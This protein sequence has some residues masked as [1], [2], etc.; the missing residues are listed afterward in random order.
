MKVTMS[1]FI[2]L[3][4][5]VDD[6]INDKIVVRKADNLLEDYC[7]DFDVNSV[8]CSRLYNADPAIC[9]KDCIGRELCPETC[10][11][12]GEFYGQKMTD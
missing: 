3:D 12:C 6:K 5:S 1:K 11:T 2:I 4:R 10:G 9:Q 8:A 7:S